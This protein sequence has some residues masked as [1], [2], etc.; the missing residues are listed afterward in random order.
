MI[1]SVFVKRDILYFKIKDNILSFKYNDFELDFEEI[2]EKIEYNKKFYF[3]IVFDF[4]IEDKEKYLIVLRSYKIKLKKYILYLDYIKSLKKDIVAIG[5]N[6]SIKIENNLVEKIDL[7]KEDN[8]DMEG[9]EYIYINEDS[10]KNIFNDICKYRSK[11]T[12]NYKLFINIIA[13]FIFVISI[14]LRNLDISSKFEKEILQYN[15]ELEKINEDI[16]NIE[17]KTDS[18]INEINDLKIED[19]FEYERKNY[20][21]IIEKLIF[22]SD[23]ILY[24]KII[25]SNENLII[26][27]ICDK[28]NYLEEIISGEIDILDIKYL[29]NKVEFKIMVRWV[30]ET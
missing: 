21:E 6:Y 5:D 22:V 13:I 17:H 7:K 16:K 29:N 8:F 15:K 4:E 25:F 28:L 24:K 11:S 14:F 2:L 12:I 30:Y 23:K 19:N 26:E 20:Y 9:I 3:I 27:G 10:L 18:I 1:I